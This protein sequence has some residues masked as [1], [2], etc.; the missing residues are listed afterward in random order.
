MVLDLKNWGLT[1]KTVEVVA[2]IILEGEN[3][4]IA[5][6][7]KGDFAGMWEFPGGKIESGETHEVAL[8][9]EIFE[10]LNLPIKV[11]EFLMTIDYEYPSFNLVMH[12]YFC[13]ALSAHFK[14]IEH[15]EVKFINIHELNKYSW[16][17]ADIFALEKIKQHF[18]LD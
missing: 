14:N 8:K 18:S 2:A 4:L 16:I 15:K 7:Q 11:N 9:R 6:R 5:Q 17:P 12:C 3:V 1:M 10:E 13:S